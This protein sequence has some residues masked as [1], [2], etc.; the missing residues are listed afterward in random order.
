VLYVIQLE[1]Q[2][3]EA[4]IVGGYSGE[5]VTRRRNPFDF[6][7]D[8]G[9]VRS[10][11]GR[12]SYT[13]GPRRSAAAEWAVRQNGDGAWTRVEYAQSYGRNWRVIAA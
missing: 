9:L 1:R 2:F 5:A 3:G 13:I 11:L 7:P 6:A 10:F 4:S 12:V 8:R